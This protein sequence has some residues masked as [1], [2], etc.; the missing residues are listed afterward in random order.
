MCRSQTSCLWD[1]DQTPYR[2]QLLCGIPSLSAPRQK[3]LKNLSWSLP[4]YLTIPP[5]SFSNLAPALPA[6]NEPA[7]HPHFYHWMT[8]EAHVRPLPKTTS[9][10]RSPRWNRPSRAASS[11]AIATDAA[12][13]L[14]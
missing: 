12:D 9:K 11:S 1:S 10:I 7:R 5:K 3:L 2:E 4:Y 14:P 6:V 8:H 13:T